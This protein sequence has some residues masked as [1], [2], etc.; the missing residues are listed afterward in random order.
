MIDTPPLGP[1]V[2]SLIVSQVADKTVFVVRWASTPR[3]MVAQCIERLSGH[4]K[5]AGVVFNFVID[6]LAQRYGNERYYTKYYN[7]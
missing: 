2:N 7:E 5:V 6:G 3:E 4:R 1:V